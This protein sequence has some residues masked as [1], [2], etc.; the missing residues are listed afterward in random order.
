MFLQLRHKK[1]I[2][3]VKMKN[4]IELQSVNNYNGL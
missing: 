2:S 3:E 1:I 4:H